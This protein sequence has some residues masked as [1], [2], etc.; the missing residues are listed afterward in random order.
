[1]KEENRPLPEIERATLA[2]VKDIR[3]RA[4]AFA[5]ASNDWLLSIPI[6]SFSKTSHNN[7]IIAK[8]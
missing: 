4:L 5:V 8:S 7:S 2:R 1:V 3:L 6:A